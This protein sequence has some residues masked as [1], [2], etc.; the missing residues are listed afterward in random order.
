MQYKVTKSLT[1]TALA[2]CFLLPGLSSAQS[3]KLYKLVDEQGNVTF[4]DIKPETETA[5]VEELDT[6]LSAA[7]EETAT[8]I[9]QIAEDAPI[10]FYS[11]TDCAACD[12]VRTH[13]KDSNLPFTEVAV[14]DDY[15]AQ[16]QMKQAVGNLNVPTVTVGER[17]LT[18]FNASAL[19]AILDVAGY[20][21]GEAAAA[22]A[23]QPA[24]EETVEADD[25][26]A[27][28]EDVTE[29]PVEEPVEEPE[30]E[31][32]TTNGEDAGADT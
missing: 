31:S 21:V 13:L 3:G 24:N 7:G 23:P 22:P 6:S 20:P 4:T 11:A 10:T 15:D 29:S 9:D 1:L 32:D 18:G 25:T 5:V 12:M 16:Q 19:D 27:A 8:N 28:D 2:A 14:G 26:G 17:S 30:N